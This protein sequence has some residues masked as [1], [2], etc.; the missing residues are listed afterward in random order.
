M[1]DRNLVAVRFSALE[2]RPEV[3]SDG[4]LSSLLAID[5]MSLIRSRMSS[6]AFLSMEVSCFA[7]PESGMKANASMMRTLPRKRWFSGEAYRQ[8]RGGTTAGCMAR[9]TSPPGYFRDLR[10]P[11]A[12]K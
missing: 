12:L 3:S 7:K 6:L 5:S 1:S 10:E 2:T 4:F 9:E 8:F 11:A